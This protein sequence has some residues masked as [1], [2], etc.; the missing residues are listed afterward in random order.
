MFAIRLSAS[1]RLVLL[2]TRSFRRKESKARNRKGSR[3]REAGRNSR[4]RASEGEVGSK[5]ERKKKIRSGM[6]TR[7]RVKAGENCL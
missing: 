4:Q 6:E 3:E 7:I 2:C 5:K 1:S